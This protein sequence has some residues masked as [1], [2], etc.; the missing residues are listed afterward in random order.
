MPGP[1]VDEFASRFMLSAAREGLQRGLEVDGVRGLIMRGLKIRIAAAKPTITNAKLSKTMNPQ[2]HK[3][4]MENLAL[5]GV[6]KEVK[7]VTKELNGTSLLNK[8]FS[9]NGFT[10][11]LENNNWR[12]VHVATHGFFGGTPDSSFFMTYDHMLNMKQLESIIRG[13]ESDPPELLTFSACQTA[14]GNDRAPLG[15][16]GIAV[17]SGVRS[18][19]GSLWPVSDDAT[20][21]LISE[22]YRR[23]LDPKLT[24]AQAFQ[25]AQLTV[26]HMPKFR[27]RFFGR[28]SF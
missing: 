16:T 25:Q 13:D 19:I 15:I 10:K 1:V 5:P 12:I 11:A 7:S 20:Q 6:A 27:S 9:L 26:L 24:K 4:L 23:L 22:F 28:H 21:I 8:D 17:E 18:A 14:E 3:Y 2:L